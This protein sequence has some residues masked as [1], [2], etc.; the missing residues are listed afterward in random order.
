MTAAA[1]V[2]AGAVAVHGG[3]VVVAPTGVVESE[4]VDVEAQAGLHVLDPQDGLAAFEVDVVLVGHG[5]FSARSFVDLG[6][7]TC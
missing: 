2:N 4:L 3:E 5:V 1:K 6:G 7:F